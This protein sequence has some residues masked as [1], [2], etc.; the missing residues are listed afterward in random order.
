M[1]QNPPAETT[2]EESA[3]H[4]K[5]E[6]RGRDEL[7]ADASRGSER[8]RRAGSARAPRDRQSD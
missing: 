1:A 7:G 4:A 6:V 3:A 5:V 2:G 8:G